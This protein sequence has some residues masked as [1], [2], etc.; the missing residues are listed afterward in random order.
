MLIIVLIL[1][2]VTKPQ[3]SHTPITP[4]IVPVHVSPKISVVPSQHNFKASF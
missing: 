4:M 1:V 3:V 2:T